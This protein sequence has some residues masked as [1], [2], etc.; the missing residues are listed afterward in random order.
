MRLDFGC[1]VA[2]RFWAHESLMTS[3]WLFGRQ[4]YWG[5]LIVFLIYSR[6]EE[7]NVDSLRLKAVFLNIKKTC[8]YI[9]AGGSI[10]KMLVEKTKTKF[11]L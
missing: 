5:L 4:Q 7:M 1:G 6:Y 10:L 3:Q 2:E 9:Y 8:Q 11:F